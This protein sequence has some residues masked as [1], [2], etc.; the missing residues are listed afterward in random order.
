[1]L[2]KSLARPAAGQRGIPFCLLTTSLTVVALAMGSTGVRAQTMWI[3]PL[4]YG[5]WFMASNWDQGVP[6]AADVVVIANGNQA[7]VGAGATAQ[8]VQILGGSALNIV[9]GSAAALGSISVTGTDGTRLVLDNSSTGGVS[10][11]AVGSGINSYLDAF[12]VVGAGSSLDGSAI[13]ISNQAALAISGSGT[14]GT[15]SITIGDGG[16][17]MF[18]GAGNAGTARI[19]SE[20]GGVVLFTGLGSAAAATI[21]NNGTSV[22]DIG[23]TGATLG[24]VESASIGSLSGS[25]NVY[26][27]DS[28]LI[29]G[30]LDGDDTIS[31]A[32]SDNFSP[33][34]NDYAIA[35]GSPAL[36]PLPG[37]ALSKVGTGTLTLSGANS[38]TGSTTVEAGV[39][40]AGATNTLSADSDHTVLAGAELAL[41]GFDQTVAALSNAGLVSTGGAPGAVLTVN[42][43]YSGGGTL[44]LNTVL[45]GDASITDRLR[46]GGDSTGTTT[47]AITNVGGGGAATVAGIRVVE[48][49][50]ASDGAFVLGGDNVFGTVPTLAA[51]AY[52]YRLYQ[53]DLETGADG[54]WYLRSALTVDGATLFAPGVPVYENYARVLADL[55]SVLTLQQ[56]LGQRIWLGAA[57]ELTAHGTGLWALVEATHAG[58][59]ADTTW[60]AAN[61][62]LMSWRG[63]IGI[64][65]VVVS[66]DGGQLIGGLFAQTAI[67]SAAVTSASGDGTIDSRG[68]GLG[69]TITWYGTQGVYVDGQAQASWFDTTLAST[70]LDQSLTRGDAGFG[71]TLSLEAGVAVPLTPEWT[72][73]PQAQLTYGEASFDSF[74]DPLGTAVSSR[75]GASGTGRL[76]VML[77]WQRGW[78]EASGEDA[79]RAKLYAIANLYNNF[80]GPAVDVDRTPVGARTIGAGAGLGLGGSLRFNDSLTL[81]G[82]LAASTG[83]ANPGR[84]YATTASFGLNGTW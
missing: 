67:G 23:L 51:G 42:G 48:V 9:H 59:G 62:D 25:G 44:A 64:D 12:V 70:L 49:A 29:L 2:L 43:D 60:S 17:V 34:V 58:F 52:T 45:G 57:D 32:I 13:S 3:G 66:S 63:R 78:G 21:I 71:Y 53:N 40:A 5:D 18:Q 46:V 20:D 82:D 73:T 65:G 54:N 22:I 8:S 35:M 69:G 1:M 47:L 14:A 81:R 16:M 61:A 84:T 11:T 33:Q 26:L 15:A 24:G 6:N 76:G 7:N 30:A 36:P 50:G 68:Y 4:E 56:R 39:L 80:L 19:T 79:G 37:G 74:T 31:G 72:L 83:L 41:N 38:Y 77:D 55:N 10:I 27:G 75:D 28:R